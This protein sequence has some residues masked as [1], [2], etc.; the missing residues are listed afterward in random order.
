MGVTISAD[1]LSIVHQGSGGEANA[2]VPDVCMTTVGPSVVPIPY[3]NHAKAADLADGTK[4]VTADGGNS[5]ALKGSQFASSTGDAGGDKK[6]MVSG[7]TEAEA[8]FTSASATVKIEGVGV[9]R[10]TDMMTMNA[11]N[12]VCFGCENP[13]VTVQPEEDTTHALHIDCRYPSGHPLAD[14]PFQLKDETGAVL[15]EGTLNGQGKVIVDGL[16]TKACTIEYGE[17]PAPFQIIYPR[18][19]NPGQETLEDDVFFD[20]ASQICVPFWVQRGDMQQRLWGY[21]GETLADSL[22]FRQ[23][24]EVEIRASL[25]LN[26][27]PGQVENIASRLIN[28]FDQQKIPEAEVLGLISTLMPVLDE[29]GILFEL[30]V[31][32]H[33]D[34]SGNN[35]LASMRHLGTGNPVEWLD[36]LDWE[37]ASTLLSRTCVDILEKTDARLGTILH[38]ANTRGY[39]YIS[40]SLKAHRDAV[41]TVRRT[42]PDDVS[43]AM[44]SLKQKITTI[45]G[46][47]EKVMVVPT[48]NQRTTQGGS[49]SDVVHS[50]KSMPAPLAINLTYDD[51]ELTPA[52]YV[53]YSVMFA[54]GEKLTGKLDAS[55]RALLVGVPQVGAE[56][57]FGLKSDAEKAEKALEKLTK[58]V[59]DLLSGVLDDMV[60]I[61]R[62]QAAAAP[63]IA[64][65]NFA[66]LQASV[67]AELDELKSRQDA[68]DDLSFLEQ[69]WSYAKN[70]GMGISTGVTEYIPDFGEFGELMDAADIGIDALVMAIATGDIDVLQRQLQQVDRAKLGLQ[71]ASMAMEILLL[72]LS[73]PDTREYLASLP[74]RFMEAMP[75]DELTRFAISQ[76]TQKGIDIAAVTGGTALAGA[77]SG[78][79]GAPVAAAAISGSVSVRNGAKALE[80]LVDVLMKIAD[81]K[82]LM[83]NH[84]EKKRHEK[85]NET[86]LPKQCPICKREKCGNRNR[87]KKGQGVTESKNYKE[88]MAKNY[89]GGFPSTHPWFVGRF[90][91]AVHHVIPIEAVKKDRQFIKAFDQF[92][93]DINTVDNLVTLPM[94]PSLACE[95]GVQR[96][97]TNHMYG[98]AFEGNPVDFTTVKKF[99]ISKDSVGLNN[100]AENTV[101]NKPYLVYPK[102]A[103]KEALKVL[104]LVKK[105]RF[106]KPPLSSEKARKMFAE[107]MRE[108]SKEILGYIHGFTWTIDWDSRDYHPKS[109]TGCSGAKKIGKISFKDNKKEKRTHN[110]PYPD[111]N[112][113]LGV[114]KFTGKL[115]L[116]K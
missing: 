54:N 46:K 9:A 83:L 13:S 32:Y 15:A 66:V 25:P 48:N 12:T 106:C 26:P 96:H 10:K 102:A 31:N 87:L 94:T 43:A 34:E 104:D 1:G 108:R 59:P 17:A 40:D 80:G 28:F 36:N 76:A 42:L 69:S 19:A 86:N 78:G 91:L 116:G 51:I 72:L 75:P 85:D 105:G 14:A 64:Q 112:H 73:D 68:F 88:N 62:R 18:P 74:R 67:E 24:L 22:D 11:G 3:S 20:R 5:I 103:K 84:H 93:F 100:F 23:M 55:G 21:V 111:R 70:A 57:E 7:T 89:P 79:I 61:A 60:N 82:K 8:K 30:F 2:S 41:S 39:T 92:N 90:T 97:Q 56:I 113:G 65:D 6:G 16:P 53:P 37:A 98:I 47:G 44:K 99:E 35:L 115:E 52:G 4:T 109:K 114:G 63:A 77:V 33:Q 71:Q 45:R 95:L 101:E 49:I 110:C 58:Q 29:H 107:Q 50:L 81:N 38:H 27:S